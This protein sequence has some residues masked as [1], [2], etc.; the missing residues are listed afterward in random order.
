MTTLAIICS[1]VYFGFFISDI[2]N[3]Y[4]NK[5][6]ICKLS[7]LSNIFV[8]FTTLLV[9]LAIFYELFSN[10]FTDCPVIV[11]VAGIFILVSYCLTNCIV[12][13]LFQKE[14]KL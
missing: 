4:K 3:L 7:N 11:Q 9:H 14:T 10:R 2:I 1:Y 8:I 12:M 13:W 6:K 5:E